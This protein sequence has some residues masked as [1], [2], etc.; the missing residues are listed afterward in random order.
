VN[1]LRILGNTA[2]TNLTTD[3][4]FSSSNL[5]IHADRFG[6]DSTSNVLVLKSG[7]TASNVS[8][9]EIYGASTSNT[10]QN[11][12]FKTKNT[13]RMRITSNGLVGIGNT[14]PTER[15]TVSGN[16]YV[17]GSNTISTGNIWGSTGNIAM[18]TY[19]S[20]KQW[21]KPN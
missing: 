20:R 11:I 2:T 9:I 4:V 15:L 21:R 16:I 5:V 12:L 7:P 13:E 8:S 6:G 17:T 1:T 10:H 18:R 3:L 14:I 19:T